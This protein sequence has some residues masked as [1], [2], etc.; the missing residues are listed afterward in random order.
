M[1]E[2]TFEGGDLVIYRRMRG[3]PLPATPLWKSEPNTGE[4][5]KQSEMK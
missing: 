5:V 2:M 4:I 3:S 1:G